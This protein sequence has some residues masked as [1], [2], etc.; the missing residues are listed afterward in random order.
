MFNVDFA[1]PV[2]QVDTIGGLES[3]PDMFFMD[4]NY[5][6]IKARMMVGDSK[7]FELRF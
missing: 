5:D 3:V 7:V 1:F 2:I 4:M 6:G